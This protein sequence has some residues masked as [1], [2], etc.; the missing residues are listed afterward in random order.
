[1]GKYTHI[2]THRKSSYLTEM[3]KIENDCSEIGYLVIFFFILNIR[4]EINPKTSMEQKN[5]VSTSSLK[6]KLCQAKALL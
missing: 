1:M 4:F 6:T 5:V 2:Y 3:K